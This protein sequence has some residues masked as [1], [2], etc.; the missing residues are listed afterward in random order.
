[1]RNDQYIKHVLKNCDSYQESGLWARPPR[2]SPRSWLANF[3][4]QE[5]KATAAAILDRLTYFSSA[6]VN[7]L[8]TGAYREWEAGR[9]EVPAVSPPA[10]T[11]AKNEWINAAVWTG[12][13]GEEPNPTDSG[14]IF[15]RL[16][17]NLLKIEQDNIVPQNTAAQHAANGGN[18]VFVDDF[19]GSGRQVRQTWTRQHDGTSF[20]NVFNGATDR[21]ALICLVATQYGLEQLRLKD[22]SPQIYAAHVVGPDSSITG[23]DR[24]PYDPPAA[25]KSNVLALLEKYSK[26]LKVDSYMDDAVSRTFG[27]HGLGLMLGFEHGRPDSTLPILWAEGPDS[28]TPLMS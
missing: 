5:E 25:S 4:E 9:C 7:D 19:I 8:F 22:I 12:I 18:V 1:M 17:R 20:A 14:Y 24:R 27:F 21:A 13:Q 10:A 2:L 23:M 6:R 11:R 28:W 26:H 16:V 3:T 15:Q